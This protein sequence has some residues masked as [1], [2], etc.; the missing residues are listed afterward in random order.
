[1]CGI[2]VLVVASSSSNKSGSE[3]GFYPYKDDRVTILAYITK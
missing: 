1:M 3:I 2:V